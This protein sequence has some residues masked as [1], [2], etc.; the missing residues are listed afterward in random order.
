M[1]QVWQRELERVAPGLRVRRNAPYRG[2]SDGLPT[3]LRRL[4]PA[5]RYVGFEMEF[6][7]ALLKRGPFPAR[8]V[9]RAL[10]TALT[11]PV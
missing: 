2:V 10:R 9:A 5:D 8:A 6:N 3:A 11:A 1:A 4:Y 7:Q